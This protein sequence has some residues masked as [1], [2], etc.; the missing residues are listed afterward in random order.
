M[1]KGSYRGWYS[2]YI[3]LYTCVSLREGVEMCNLTHS[4]KSTS[5]M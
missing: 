4:M 1:S 2:K 3:T 5:S